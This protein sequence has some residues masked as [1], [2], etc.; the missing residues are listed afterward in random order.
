MARRRARRNWRAQRS[1][2]NR[3][4]TG[5]RR[6]APVMKH[7]SLRATRS[8]RLRP[9]LPG[10]YCRPNWNRCDAWSC[11]RHAF[12]SSIEMGFRSFT[13]VPRRISWARRIGLRPSSGSERQRKIARVWRWPMPNATWR[14]P[15]MLCPPRKPGRAQTNGEAR[16]PPTGPWSNLHIPEP[17]RKR[18][19]RNT[20]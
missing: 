11:D 15:P 6:H 7:P 8:S 3:W 16:A 10:K 17:C 4:V 20:P 19:R 1:R 14:R 18:D 12:C 9:S 2:G 13:F 5:D